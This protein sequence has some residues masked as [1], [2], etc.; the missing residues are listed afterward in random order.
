MKILVAIVLLW[1]A[2]IAFMAI[3]AALAVAYYDMVRPL[4][5]HRRSRIQ[6]P[7]ATAYVVDPFPSRRYGH[8][9]D[10]IGGSGAGSTTAL[11]AE[12]DGEP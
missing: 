4:L 1:A 3:A 7:A 12:E 8:P 6:S 2:C 5:D 10:V 9:L 11:F